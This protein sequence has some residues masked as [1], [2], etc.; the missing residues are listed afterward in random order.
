ME[1]G[2]V[3]R[4]LREDRGFT[5]EQLAAAAG[6]DVLAVAAAEGGRAQPATVAVLLAALGRLGLERSGRP[7]ADLD[8]LGLIAAQRSMT[9]EE[10]LAAG[11]DLCEFAADFA[12]AARR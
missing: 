9:V 8:D 1:L 6:V 4:Q 2:L 7:P 3:L 5:T 11:L 10:R 12:G